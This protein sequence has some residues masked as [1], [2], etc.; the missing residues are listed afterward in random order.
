MDKIAKALAPLCATTVGVLTFV[1]WLRSWVVIVMVVLGLLALITA[2]LSLGSYTL[3]A[4]V[5]ISLWIFAG[6]GAMA[7]VTA[8]LLWLTLHVPQLFPTLP[9]ETLKEVSATFTGAFTTFAGVAITKDMEGGGGFFWPGTQFKT[10]L[11]A[12]FSKPPL[13]PQPDTH[14]WEAVY[15]D[16]VGGGGPRGWG[17]RARLERAKILTH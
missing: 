9:A 3:F 6:I 7:G 8:G 15:D 13:T 1:G 11:S 12:V 14:E 16:R 10:R 17:F 5:V 4:G 2:R